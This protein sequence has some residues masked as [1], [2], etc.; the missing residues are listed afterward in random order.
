M[1]G[2]ERERVMKCELKMMCKR[3]NRNDKGEKMTKSN[4]EYR[5]RRRIGK[6]KDALRRGDQ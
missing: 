1:T 5:I 4:E 6:I 2:G 3:K